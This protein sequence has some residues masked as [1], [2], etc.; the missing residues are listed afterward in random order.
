MIYL[1]G[2]VLSQNADGTFEFEFDDESGTQTVALGELIEEDVSSEDSEEEI[3]SDI[4]PPQ[5]PQSNAATPAT[6]PQPS[7][8]PLTAEQRAKLA[9]LKAQW[10][11]SNA[12]PSIKDVSSVDSSLVAGAHS[13]DAFESSSYWLKICPHLSIGGTLP[14]DICAVVDDKRRDVAA[15]SKAEFVHDGF[16][17]LNRATLGCS[18]DEVF[19]LALGIV[20]LIKFGW[21]P[22]FIYM[23]DEAWTVVERARQFLGL[24]TG[25]S[26]FIGDVYAWYVD[27]HN[28]QRGWGPHRSVCTH[29]CIRPVLTLRGIL[30]DIVS[31]R[32]CP[33]LT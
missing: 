33:S 20:Q 29:A 10:L 19:Q 3:V 15:R 24:A 30:S 8:I 12:L 18:D 16:F 9:V 11:D 23:Y 4:D 2:T 1:S 32:L 21:P 27:P 25:G 22:T 31:V 28:S 14:G 17:L 7:R 5:L 6:L 13:L 26:R